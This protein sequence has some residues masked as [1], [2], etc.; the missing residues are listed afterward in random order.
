[1]QA[2]ATLADQEKS[3]K[4]LVGFFK[5]IDV[6]P[7]F[8]ALLVLCAASF[9]PNDLEGCK[10]L[11]SADLKSTKE[12][13]ARVLSRIKSIKALKAAIESCPHGY[14]AD[15]EL[16]N[17]CKPLIRRVGAMLESQKCPTMCRNELATASGSSH[18]S[19]VERQQVQQAF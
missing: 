19:V 4:L 7:K 8:K 14:S 2:Q 9:K 15:A 13:L 10:E 18:S 6:V 16:A 5:D 12:S 3:S 11:V 17:G 1:M